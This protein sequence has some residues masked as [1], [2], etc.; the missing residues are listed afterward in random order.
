MKID[1]YVET[2]TFVIQHLALRDIAENDASYHNYEEENPDWLAPGEYVLPDAVKAVQFSV[3]ESDTPDGEPPVL[4]SVHFSRDTVTAP[5]VLEVTIDATDDVSGLNSAEVWFYCE[6]TG[7][8]LHTWL[9][10]FYYDEDTRTE[11][12][13]P[14][15][16]LH[17]KLK[18]DQ[19]VETGTFA[20]HHLVLRDVAENDASY[21]DYEEENPEWLAPGEYVLPEAVKQKTLYVINTVPDVTTSVSKPEFVEQIQQAENGS[22]IVADFSGETTMPEEAFE[23]IA[24]TDKTLELTSEGITWR[25]NGKDIV[26]AAKPIELDVQIT[27]AEETTTG[28]GQAIQNA[29]EDNP[30]IVMKFAENGELPGEAT[31]QVKVDYAMRQ[32]LGTSQQLCVYYYN[33][34]TGEMELVA[35]D[36]Q[37]IDDTYVEFTITHC[38]YYVLTT[39]LPQYYQ[40]AFDGYKGDDFGGVFEIDSSYTTRIIREENCATGEKIGDVLPFA[41]TK[42]PQWD[43]MTFDGWLKYEEEGIEQGGPYY[44]QSGD[45]YTTAEVMQQTVPTYNVRYV[46]KWAE[47]PMSYYENLYDPYW[48]IG[49]DEETSIHVFACEVCSEAS[50]TLLKDN[51][52]LER[53][54]HDYVVNLS[55]GETL[56][57]RGYDFKDIVFWDPSRDFLGWNVCT[58]VEGQGMCQIEGTETMNTA[59]MLNYPAM[60]SQRIYFVGQWAGDDSAYYSMVRLDTFGGAFE[61]CFDGISWL[62]TDAWG[63]SRSREGGTIGGE[64][65]RYYG[66]H[67]QIRNFS[68]EGSD[69]LGWIEYTVVNGDYQ[70]VSGSPIDTDTMLAKTVT[71]ND[72]VFVARWSNVP[73][74]DYENYAP[75]G[76][77]GSESFNVWVS[78]GWYGR[79]V[80][81]KNGECESG[82]SG[83]V[84][85]QV[86]VGSSLLAEGYEFV[87][88]EPYPE[89]AGEIRNRTG[90]YVGTHDGD[91]N[92]ERLPGSGL[93]S[94]SEMLNYTI[95]AD[96]KISFE[97]Q[98][99][100]EPDG[101]D[102]P[103]DG[104][105]ASITADEEV[106]NGDRILA[107]VKAKH[108][109]ESVFAAGEVVVSYDSSMLTFNQ[110][111]SNLGNATVK[112]DNGILILEDYGEDKLFSNTA[113]V[114]AFDTKGT[115][116]VTLNLE[117]AAFVNKENAVKSDLIP[118]ALDPASAVVTISRSR[119]PVALDEIFNGPATATDGESYTFYAADMKH[120]V[121]DSVSVMM[122]GNPAPVTDNGDGSYTVASVNGPLTVTGSRSEKE[123][124]VI[125]EGSGAEDITNVKTTATYG[126]E[127]VFRL[128]DADGA[129]Y[130]L[131]SILIDGQVYTGYDVTGKTVTIDGMHIH[132]DI[133]ITVTK[134]VTEASVTVEGSGAGAAAGYEPKLELGKDYTLTLKPEAGYSY[135]VTAT[136]KGE[137]AEVI[138]NSDNT[139][140]VKKVNGD[141]VFTVERTV[142][143]DG[144]TVTQYLKIN[145]ANVWLVQYKTEVAEGKVP[146]YDGNPMFWSD[147]YNSYCYLVITE[148]LD[149]EEVKSKLDIT[150]GTAAVIGE[151]MDV[152]DSGKV[153]ASD[154][155]LV[156]NMYNAMYD[157]FDGDVTVEKYLRADVNKD[158]EI[159]VQDAAAI[160]AHILA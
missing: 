65:E 34:Q 88:W 158:G 20:I 96:Q 59:Q 128:P 42:D 137:A 16:K 69:F 122:G 118:A 7:K 72:M 43:G 139:Y 28:S 70:M 54:H 5:G 37:V 62:V 147:E 39:A 132:G 90:W 86:P 45:T 36:L 26:N 4:N 63:N 64:N 53:N 109:E 11:V 3:V 56:G 99:D 22:Y 93:L 73:W 105:V 110:E 23:A 153:D 120:Y 155:Q 12:R 103:I 71:E 104:Y 134:T 123:F 33:N 85:M 32:Y 140:T 125:F 58:F 76:G 27:K 9:D 87:D 133:V 81:M 119:Y 117:S 6:E 148:T 100:E 160:I 141:L 24:G 48:G 108:S 46:A 55:Q 44:L 89:H 52:V 102:V 113:Y 145:D 97:A 144:V 131:G 14:D 57:S 18:I 95:P 115:G 83:T 152:N 106:S 149:E 13:Y 47:I 151:S 91:W 15:G 30:G 75:G 146:T 135:T 41:I 111:A 74:E 1:Q 67:M 50:F 156:Y 129:V 49:G 19:Y 31:I 114:L 150:D 21:H 157:S 92:F 82:V 94:D 136:V 60:D 116:T 51:E 78:G 80:T 159:N 98:W 143:T 61:V 84:W 8:E 29:L 101:G 126:I 79:F 10:A 2:G 66:N 17:G 107:L 112:D 142:M 138:D 35:E 77:E 130:S 154:A 38:S 25:F 40:V 127:Y 68:R 121:Y 124:K